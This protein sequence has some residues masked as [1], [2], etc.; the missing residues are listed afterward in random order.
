[1]TK[2][3]LLVVFWFPAWLNAQLMIN[4]YCHRNMSI[5]K[6]EFGKN[7]D[8]IELYNHSSQSMNL[9]GYSLSNR[10]GAPKWFFPK[11]SVRPHEKVFVFASGRSKAYATHHWE[12]AVFCYDNWRWKVPD[13]ELPVE[14]NTLSFNDSDWNESPGG[15]GFGDGDDGTQVSPCTS[16][17]MRRKFFVSDS[18]ALTEAVLHAD[19]DD[20]FV[21]YLNGVEF[22][23]AGLGSSGTPVPF[24]A[25]PS[26]QHE[27]SMYRG[28]MPERFQ[29]DYSRLKQLIRQ[30]ENVLAIQT[31]NAFQSNDMTS[32]FF[33]S[34]GVADAQ[35]FFRAVPHWFDLSP[36]FFHASF[37]LKTGDT[38]FLFNPHGILLD[39][40]LIRECAIDHSFGRT[41]DGNS[42]KSFFKIP[43]PNAQNDSLNAFDFYEHVPVIFPQS[44]FYNAAITIQAEADSSVVI[45][46]ATGGKIPDETS[47]VYNH[48]LLIDTT[49][50]ITFRAFGSNNYQPSAPVVCTYFI[51]ENSLSL[52]VVSIT[53]SPEHL[54]SDSMGIYTKGTQ[55]NPFYPFFGANFWKKWER[56][57]YIEY[58]D[59]NKNRVFGVPFGLKI[60]GNWSRGQNQKGLRIDFD[61]KYGVP[62]VNYP[63][64]SDKPH[65]QTYRAFN[66][67]NAGNDFFGSRFRDALMQRSVKHTHVD[68][69][70]Y[71]PVIVFLNGEYWGLYELRE[72]MD[73]EYLHY[74]LGVSPH[75]VDLLSYDH[76]LGF[77][78]HN[79]TDSAFYETFYRITSLSPGD[80][81]FFDLVNQHIDIPNYADYFITQIFYANSDWMGEWTNNIKCWR[82]RKA[83][84]KWRYM[85][86][87]LDYGCGFV[88]PDGN[89]TMSKPQDYM[90]NRARR[91]II[92]NEHAR[93]F[94]HI[95]ANEK[96]RNYLLNR[97]ADLMN[98]TL[99]IDSFAM[100]AQRMKMEIAPEIPRHQSKWGGSWQMFENSID[101][102]LEFVRQRPHYLFQNTIQE[103]GLNKAE[104]LTILTQPENA[105]VVQ[106]N[107]LLL[108]DFPFFGTYFDGVP[109]FLKA[110]PREGF[111]FSHW[112]SKKLFMQPVSS[113]SLLLNLSTNDTIVA[114]F[115]ESDFSTPVR[116]NSL[117]HSNFQ[118]SS[119]LHQW[120]VSS[121][122]NGSFFATLFDILGKPI[123]SKTAHG[124]C[125]FAKQQLPAG[126]YIIQVQ[127][128]KHMQTWKVIKQ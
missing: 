67:R 113:D 16:V 58:F 86:W 29:I 32:N 85:L 81:T 30:G 108:N 73:Q 119:S 62:K 75:A 80:S 116:E 52:P 88:N 54:W 49:T 9:G 53:T 5:V 27:A 8:W 3:K 35:T 83:G 43:S 60:H 70:A 65:I 93:L 1:V 79:G 95:V 44:G 64:I 91:P 71:A 105:G 40:M 48:P 122:D 100:L 18:A 45:R 22:A 97:M 92:T 76:N 39:S 89:T 126:V 107:T 115:K 61:H 11:T 110:S 21:A 106:L 50:V 102:M 87:D 2:Y 96:F 25:Y 72:K 26:I 7:S 127:Q 84:S 15:I 55:A 23:R 51:G 78:V 69:M 124:R 46:Y 59:E 34:F 82:E 128:K 120:T 121:I 20:A 19:Y 98:T 77:Q 94:N 104:T 10:T 42:S 99:K 66:L 14:W 123:E 56:L 101:S 6:D 28:M 114:V 90:W 31:H 103:F 36:S 63:L 109:V 33:L 47:D 41:Q 118:L 12:T 111:E 13:E 117:V 38:L 57:S 68:Y 37:K 17:F 112:Q 24:N 125:T 74:N 4:E